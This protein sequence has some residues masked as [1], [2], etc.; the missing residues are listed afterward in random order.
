MADRV[1]SQ[2]LFRVFPHTSVDGQQWQRIGYGVASG[3]GAAG[4]TTVVAAS[5][6]SGG[7]DAYNGRYWIEMVSGT[8]VGQW[9]RIVDDDGSGTYT[10]ENNGFSAQI[11]SGDRFAVWKSPEPVIV[12]DARQSSTSFSDDYRDEDDDFWEGYY[13]MP[14]TGACR[15]EI[16][17]ISAFDQTG[18]AAEG[19]FTTGA[20]TGTIAAGDVCLVGKFVEVAIDSL[21]KG[22]T[23]VPRL[24]NR[25]NY[26][27]GAGS[28]GGRDG[29]YAFTTRVH[30]SGSLA[31]DDAEANPSALSPLFSAA[32]LEE[33]IG[34]SAPI[35]SGSSTT[36]I[37]VDTAKW[38]STEIGQLVMHNGNVRRIT[39]QTDGAASE[40]TITVSPPLPVAPTD[41]D[42]LYAMRQYRK[43]VDAT[44][45]YPCGIEVEVDGVRTIM[46]GCKGS[47][48]IT[49]GTPIEMAW[50][51]SVDHW[52]TE[53]EDAPYNPGTAYTTQPDIM[54]KDMMAWA[55]TTQI[56]IKG[57][58]ATVG[59]E[60][61]ARMVTGAYGVNGRAGFHHMNYGCGAT[62]REIMADSAELE[63]Q[64]RFLART[65]RAILVQCG[66]ADNCLAF[67]MPAAG[68]IEDA[69]HENGDGLLDAPNVLQAQ[70]AGVGVD[71][72]STIVKVPDWVI[73]IA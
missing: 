11:D 8:C 24:T 6:S 39:A 25:V 22:P 17:Q 27:V 29:E 50:S 23:Y 65:Q 5:F 64:N 13:V 21:P 19:L 55:D 62:Y 42:T 63:A 4:G 44:T 31:A 57:L 9:K 7:A 53:Y 67:C 33:S 68:Q 16:V 1:W 20:L 34:T 66:A 52:T 35:S 10:L 54:G 61:T 47:L 3:N 46:T 51:F 2:A 70:D 48:E 14:I 49:F 26:S 43:S 18:G 72:D 41:G 30:G 60:V 59:R 40:D 56:D 32:G 38:E 12:V 45:L 73:A 58:T 15:G 37:L 71:P 69:T 36:A 28:L